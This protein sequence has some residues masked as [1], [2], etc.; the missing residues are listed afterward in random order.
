MDR[1]REGGG[2]WAGRDGGGDEESRDVDDVLDGML[3][4]MAD[5]GT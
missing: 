4:F 2:G 3:F 5:A 1:P